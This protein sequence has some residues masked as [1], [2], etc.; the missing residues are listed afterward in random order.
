M[1][2]D[3]LSEEYVGPVGPLVLS[4]EITPG[5]FDRL[6][7]KIAGNA[8]RFVAQNKVNEVQKQ[9]AENRVLKQLEQQKIAAQYAKIRGRE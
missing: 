6:L 4:G 2:H 7:A 9:V 8:N 1:D 3:P 5:N